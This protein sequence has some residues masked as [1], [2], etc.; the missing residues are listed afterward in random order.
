MKLSWQQIPSPVISDILCQ[1]SF[2]GVVIDTEHGSF[3]TETLY[4]CIQVVTLSNKKCF[5]RLTEINKSLIRLCLDAGSHGLIFSTIESYEDALEVKK[6]ALYPKYGGLRGLGLVRE[7]SWG[8]KDLVCEPPTLIAQIETLKGV[9]NI[10]K[11]WES[12][13]FDF[14]MIGP[15]DLSA[16]L[17][18]PGDFNSKEYT[19]AI[20]AVKKIITIEKMAVHIPTNVNDEKKKYEGYGIMALGMDTTSIIEKYK[21]I[22]ENA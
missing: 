8:I 6:H 19:D 9:N 13:V 10:N 14:C 12:F 5:V 21:E 15:Y 17:G 2:D 16:S 7:N 11:I 3:N 4:A 1:N 22:E 20:D 18:F